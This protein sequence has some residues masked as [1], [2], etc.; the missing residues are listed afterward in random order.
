MRKRFLATILCVA[1]SL[2]CVGA[3]AVSAEEANPGYTIDEGTKTITVSTADGLVAV[4]GLTNQTED[5]YRNYNI[6]LAADI[7]LSTATSPY[8][9]MCL[10]DQKKTEEKNEGAWVYKGTFDGAGHTVSNLVLLGS[11]TDRYQAL[12]AASGSGCVIKNL[13]VEGV[14]ITGREFLGS[15]IGRANGD[16]T[17][18]NCHVKNITI[19]ANTSNGNNVGGLIG[20]FDSANPATVLIENCTVSA[21]LSSFQKV[22]GVCGS[23]GLGGTVPLDVTFRNIVVAGEFKTFSTALDQGCAGIFAY[24]GGNGS[25]EE[26]VVHQKVTF[27]NCISLAKFDAP[28]KASIVSRVMCGIYTVKNCIGLG[29]FSATLNFTAAAHTVAVTNSFIFDPEAT[30][31]TAPYF[32]KEVTDP[33]DESIKMTIDEVVVPFST[34]TLPV[35]DAATVKAKAAALY[36]DA[37]EAFK[38]VAL[39]LVDNAAGHTHTFDQEVVSAA[40]LKTEATCNQKA[41][42]YKSCTCG[43]KGEETFEAGEFAAHDFAKAWSKNETQHWHVCMDCQTEKSEIGEHTFSAWTVTHEATEKREGERERSCTVC[44]YTEVEKIDKL[45]AEEVTTSAPESTN[46]NEGATTTT[47]AKSNEKGCGSIL[48]GSSVL[49]LL[50]IPAGCALIRKKKED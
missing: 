14:N 3:Y 33:A 49:F 26:G 18:Q 30:G 7:D 38:T 41:V 34:A 25:D 37:P 21:N 16:L 32:T 20:R 31:T 29:G 42:Y 1:M 9:P 6:T 12:I 28:E 2:I 4:S 10:G 22:G 23:E 13:N 15:L 5:T 17:V 11:A 43:M 50:A 35:I 46:A 8:V 24:N 39:A 45:T 48:T 47:A 40:F 27:E 44:G 19:A 36:A